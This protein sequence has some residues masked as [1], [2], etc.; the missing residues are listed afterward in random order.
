MKINAMK[1]WMRRTPGL[2]LLHIT[3]YGLA[4]AGV[5]ALAYCAIVIVKTNVLQSS[6]SIQFN[7]AIASGRKLP[8][9][10]LSSAREGGVL[11]QLSIPRLELNVMV[12]E[13][14]EQAD[15]RYAVGHI[16]GTALPW[17]RGNVGIAGHRDRFFRRL[18]LIH[19]GDTITLNTLAGFYEYRVIAMELVKPEDVQVL[20]PD[21]NDSM[22]LV[23]C[24]PFYYVG[25]APKRFIIKAERLSHI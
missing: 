12:V 22:T 4:A 8:P 16:P 21:R 9:A 11:G 7:A 23:T 20:A 24:F 10:V 2:R 17:E 15:L 3:Q 25:P 5:L 18:R 1:I 6:E 13:G 14:V 19:V